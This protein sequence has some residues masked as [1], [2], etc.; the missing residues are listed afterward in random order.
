ML[1]KDLINK[2]VVMVVASE[3]FRDEEYFIPKEVL[4]NR[5]VEVKTASN[6]LGIAK[7]AGGQEAAVDLLVADVNL[8]DFDA[9]VFIGGSG[10]LQNLDNE[11]S[12]NLTKAT[13]KQ[14]KILAA[15]CISPV[16][17][18]KAGV[19]SGKEATVWSSP[20]DQEPVKI[21]EENG[22]KYVGKKVAIDNKIITANGPLAA[23]EFGEAIIKAIEE[24]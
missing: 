23:Q 13:I 9:V 12:Y 10:A 16:I 6:K 8:A 1:T 22:A 11:V 4:E 20:L 3:N 2:K 21:L 15:I 18:A 7:G 14:G 24:F 5:E 19:L 17:L